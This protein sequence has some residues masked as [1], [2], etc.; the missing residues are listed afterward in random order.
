MISLGKWQSGPSPGTPR[1]KDKIKNNFKHSQE[2]HAHETAYKF[3][4]NKFVVWDNY[5]E[6]AGQMLDAALSGGG[7]D[8]PAS[9]AAH[10]V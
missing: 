1:A 7:Y 4:G 6:A 5:S 9:L 3:D 2:R 8:A 10:A